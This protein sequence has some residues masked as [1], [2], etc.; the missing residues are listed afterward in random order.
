M[1]VGVER[2]DRKTGRQWAPRPLLSFVVRAVVMLLPIVAGVV[3]AVLLG[4]ALPRPDSVPSTVAWWAVF[5]LVPLTILL[6]VEREARRLL[7]LATLLELSLMFPDRAPSR[8]KLARMVGSPADLQA[9]LRRARA[10]GSLDEA[11][12]TETILQ[13]VTMLSAHDRATRG[14]SE[15]VRVYADMIGKELG[16]D[17]AELD[18]LRWASLLHDI[19]KLEVDSGILNKPGRPDDEEWLVIRRHPEEGARITTALLP[20]LGEWAN[21]VAHHHE[22]WD[23]TGYPGG[24]RGE[25]ISLGGRIVAVAD[26][27]EVMTAGRPYVR[28][29]TPTAARRELVAKSG[30]HFDPAVVRAF[31]N[32]GVGRLWLLA[33]AGV[34]FG[35]IPFF[36]GLRWATS[37]AS[38]GATAVTSA[39]A[40]LALSTAGFVALPTTPAP[41]AGQ[42]AGART[43]TASPAGPVVSADPPP[44]PSPS[45]S[46]SPS[47][48]ATPAPSP[49]AA[50]TPV[51]QRS[52]SAPAPSPSPSGRPSPAPTPTPTPTRATPTSCTT[53]QVSA[54]Y[55]TKV[56]D[57][58]PVA[59]FGSFS[60][61]ADSSWTATVDYGDGSGVRPLALALK[62]FTLSHTYTASG[63]WTVTVRVIGNDGGCGT[64]SQSVRVNG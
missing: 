51:A 50:P 3:A 28:P 42:V 52:T 17:R 34:W 18:R 49:S 43:N 12:R 36:G 56:R 63:R 27:Y 30:M 44:A 22:H 8:F 35:Y 55:P 25:Q 47:A 59:G 4:R 37:A 2:G 40:V 41:A 11:E 19:G 5:I 31:L 15:R 24:L 53:I 54:T 14:H 38:R 7:P 23:G 33:G 21:T 29:L 58:R 64:W 57:D 60:D 1:A 45:P 46:P 61:S 9:R 6:V 32:L 62:F 10:A 16:L 26:A 39:G 48:S 13:L 20:W